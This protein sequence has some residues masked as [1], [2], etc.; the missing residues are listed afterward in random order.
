[1]RREQLLGLLTRPVTGIREPIDDCGVF[2]APP[3]L[4]ERL[5]RSGR[6]SLALDDD[7]PPPGRSTRT[8]PSMA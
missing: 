8:H 1:M 4:I 6:V 5:W 7:E 2:G 3:S